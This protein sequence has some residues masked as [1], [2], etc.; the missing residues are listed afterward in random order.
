MEIPEKISPR[1]KKLLEGFLAARPE[2]FSERAGLATKS[3]ARTEGQP[4][5]LR[6]ATLLEDILDGVQVVIREAELIVGCKTPAILGSPLYPEIACDWVEKELDWISLRQ[7]APFHVSEE[8]KEALRREVFGYWRGKQVY[9][10][11]MEALPPEIN[12]AAQEGLFFHYFLNRSIGHITV[13]YERVLKLGFLGLKEEVEAELARIDYESPGA[14]NKYYLLVAMHKCCQAAIR[15]ALRYA[16]ET[17]RLAQVEPDPE[18]QAELLRIAEICR[19]VPAHP[20]QTFHESLQAFYF[21]HLILN[22]ESN[23]YAIGPGRFDQYLYPYYRADL[24]AGRLTRSQAFELLACL[25][26]KLNELTVVKEGSTAKAS[27]TYNDFQNLNLGGQTETGRD[28]VNDLSYLCLKVTSSL[29][30]PQPQVS[31][32][33]SEKTPERF[34]VEACRVVSQG[35]GMPALFNEDEKTQSLLGKGKTLADARRG[36]INGCVEPVVPGKDMMASSGYFNLVK[37]LELALNNGVNPLTGVQ[38]GPQTGAA[39]QLSSLESFMEAFRR[40][41]EHGLRLKVIYDGIA[42]GV[43]AAFCPVPFTSLLVDDCLERGLDFHDGGAHYNQPA[44]CGVGTGTAADS[45]A[46]IK[47]LVYEEGA[48]SLEALVDTLNADFDEDEKL[49]QV[50]RTRPPK[51]GNGDEYVDDLACRVV[52]M[53][54]AELEKHHNPQGVTYAANMIPTT[55]HIWFGDLNGATPDGRR[56]GS[57]LSEGI[58]PVQ[59]MDRCGPT[60]VVQSMARLDHARCLGTLLNMRFHPTALSGEDGIKKFAGLV[61][62]YFKLGGHHMQFNVLSSEQMRLAQQDPQSYQDLIV[63]V[64]GYSDYFVRLSKDLQDEIISRTEHG[65]G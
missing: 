43:Y 9:N 26:I 14:L 31:V 62:T 35:F 38:L 65:L 17:E 19:R 21:T 54:A 44:V 10:R 7:E 1:I 25:W 34:L 18:R 63:R 48:I 4:V 3:Y 8:T 45:L 15:F 61:R 6:R 37:C 56:A 33:I 23:A 47:K 13:D 49:R 59:G 24:D 60:A 11:I 12:Q 41:V 51:W 16:S 30:L 2:V 42:R 39:P 29:R 5:L 28:A 64:A 46:S 53:F 57:P 58:S 40:Q 27:N 52:E 50:L 32:L 55:T 22:L 20:A 36:G